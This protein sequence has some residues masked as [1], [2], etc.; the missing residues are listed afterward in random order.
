[1]MLMAARYTAALITL[2][3]CSAPAMTSVVNAQSGANLQQAVLTELREDRSLRKLTVSVE[4]DQVTL[5]GEVRTFWEKNEA[6]RRT[7]DVEAIQKYAH[8]RMWDHIE[9]GLENGVVAL[10]GQV[11]PE[12]NKA[13]ELFERIAKIRGVQDIQ[14]NIESLPPNQQDNSLRDTIAQRLFQSE[15]FE[16]FRSGINTPFHIIV[17][18]SVVTLVGY[19]QGQIERIEMERIV[20]QTQGVLRTDNQLQTLR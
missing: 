9:G 7:F 10:Y 19:V 20:G 12:R 18:N 8:Y 1:M 11:T 15:H 13:R 6:L 4:G 2:S 17:R 3:F 16:R 5:T 14:M